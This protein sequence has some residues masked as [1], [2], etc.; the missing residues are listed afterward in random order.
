MAKA[1]DSKPLQ[2]FIVQ[3]LLDGGLKPLVEEATLGASGVTSEDWLVV[4]PTKVPPPVSVSKAASSDA[5]SRSVKSLEFAHGKTREAEASVAF[6]KL[7]HAAFPGAALEP[8]R[9]RLLS[10]ERPIPSRFFKANEHVDAFAAGKAAFTAAT[11][12]RELSENVGEQKLD[13]PWKGIRQIDFSDKG[14][15]TKYTYD[16]LEVDR[17][18]KLPALVP[19]DWT[20][21][22]DNRAPP[23]FIALADHQ[24]LPV[25]PHPSVQLQVQGTGSTTHSRFSVECYPSNSTM[26]VVGEVYSPLG[27]EDPLQ[28]T[29]QKLLQAER[30]VQFLCAKEEKSVGDC[31]LGVVFLGPHM[32]E[33]VASQ[34][35]RSLDYY[36]VLLP[37]MWSLHKMKRVLGNHLETFH[38]VVEAYLNNTTVAQLA[39]KVQELDQ[40]TSK[41]EVGGEKGMEDER[42]RRC[43]LM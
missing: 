38:P 14:D 34:L 1:G 23:F 12:D 3:A 42:H 11:L 4:V 6:W 10:G 16:M 21:D 13:A 8:F 5:S 2:P 31:V 26:Y 22:P 36:K 15:Y 18:L 32:D 27:G 7:T 24:Q 17:L 43:L 39:Q 9:N 37:C 28:R 29:V 19:C 30:T 20:R 35:Y 41:G 25:R 40:K 33:A